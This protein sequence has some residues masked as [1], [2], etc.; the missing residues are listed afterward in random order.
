M[1]KINNLS[2]NNGLVIAIIGVAIQLLTFYAAPA[3]LGATWFGIVTGIIVLGVYI[4]FTLD[5]RK[6]VGG[7]WTFKDAF[8][9]LFLMSIVAN[10]T[11]T[12]FNY[13]FYKFIEP[14]AYEKVIGYVSEGL[15]V[16][17]EKMGMTQDQID[18]ALESVVKTLKAQYLP[19]P[20]D[21]LKTAG[22]LIL[23]GVVLSLIFAAIFKKNPPMFTSIEEEE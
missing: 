9:G 10:F 17:Y 19:E 13:V 16:T 11:S 22:I 12:A 21:L 2:I 4:L 18:T 23:L 15:T 8:K 6:K 1:E 3:M 14:G 20:L 7:Y 5:M